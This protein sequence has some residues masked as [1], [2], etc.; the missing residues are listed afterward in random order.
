MHLASQEQIYSIYV[1]YPA[2]LIRQKSKLF[3]EGRTTARFKDELRRKVTIVDKNHNRIDQNEIKDRTDV[4]DAEQ[5]VAEMINIK[6]G[7]EG[8]VHE[9][10]KIL[11]TNW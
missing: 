9:P 4:D 7:F 11:L 3:A 10:D 5:E 2:L 6:R 1:N 8:F